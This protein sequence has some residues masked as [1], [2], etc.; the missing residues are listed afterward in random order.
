[1]IWPLGNQFCHEKEREK[2]CLVSGASGGVVARPLMRD[3]KT[4]LASFREFSQARSKNPKLLVAE[5]S[6]LTELPCDLS[7]EQ[8]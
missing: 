8:G 7:F 4:E 6:Q 2:R 1:M 5:F 3:Q